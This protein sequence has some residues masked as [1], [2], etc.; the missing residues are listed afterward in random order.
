MSLLRHL[1]RFQR[2]SQLDSVHCLLGWTTLELVGRIRAG[3]IPLN[4]LA[5]RGIRP[6]QLIC[7]VR[8]G[9]ADLLLLPPALGRVRPSA[10]APH[11]HSV[12]LVAVFAH[13][14]EMFVGVR[15]CIVFR[16]FYALIGSWRSK[17]EIGAYYFQL[18]QGTAGSYISAFS[19]AKWEDWRDGW[20]IA[21]T[22]ANDRLELRTGG[23][24]SDRSTWKAKPSLPEGL[25]PVLNRVKTLAKGGLTSMMVLG[26]F[27][28]R[29]IAPLQQRSRMA[30]MY[31]G[32][33]DCCRIMR[34]P[35]IDLT[36]AELEAAIRAV[37]V[38]AYSLESLS[39]ETDQ[40]PMRGP[41]NAVGGPSVDADPRRRWP[42]SPVGG[43]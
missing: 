14:M 17:R 13:L 20:V 40:G 9:A 27:L 4:D 37:T 33:S 29:R 15:P 35:G 30:Y 25:D 8:A 2:E 10:L 39:S 26:N 5:A 19:S 1:R 21:T 43:R 3:S 36:R 11:P 28:R 32:S 31:T 41:G 16:H 24:L 7:H 34:G 22:D 12:L 42:G 23:P 6:L 18:R 38:E